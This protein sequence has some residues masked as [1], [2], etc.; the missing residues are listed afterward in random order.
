MQVY[1]ENGVLNFADFY[2]DKDGK[3][4]A[5]Y[6]NNGTTGIYNT[7]DIYK[8]KSLSDEVLLTFGF[9]DGG[10][11]TTPEMM[12]CYNRLKNKIVRNAKCSGKDYRRIF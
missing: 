2:T 3:A 12:E 10:G 6:K 5:E 9:G 1:A 11:G 4:I 8:D 7:W